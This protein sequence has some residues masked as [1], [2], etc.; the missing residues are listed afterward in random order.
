M[1]SSGGSLL[2]I[3]YP[4]QQPPVFNRV[5]II[6]EP[7]LDSCRQHTSGISAAGVTVRLDPIARHRSATSPSCSAFVNSSLGRFSPKFIIE[8]LSDPLQTG[9]SHSLPNQ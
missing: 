4:V 6:S 2:L 3:V 1:E 8:S 7:A 5:L 9:S